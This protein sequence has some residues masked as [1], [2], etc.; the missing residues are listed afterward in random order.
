MKYRG[1]KVVLMGDS[2]ESI[3]GVS[4]ERRFQQDGGPHHTEWSQ[5]DVDSASRERKYLYSATTDP[6]FGV[7]RTEERS[8]ATDDPKCLHSHAAGCPWS[9]VCCFVGMLIFVA[10][11][12]FL[13][14]NFRFVGR[15]R[16]AC[17]RL[18]HRRRLR[19]RGLWSRA[20]FVRLLL[21][22]LSLS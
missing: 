3:T 22:W 2:I 6:P 18:R 14:I 21:A 5:Q 9:T 8:D 19:G 17:R 7:S 12:V 13:R 10:V 1:R 16:A 20:L 4:R 15:E 11:V